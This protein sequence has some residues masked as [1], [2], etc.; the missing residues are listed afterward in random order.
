VMIPLDFRLRKRSLGD[1]T[2]THCASSRK[3]AICWL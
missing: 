1:I 2:S 3:D